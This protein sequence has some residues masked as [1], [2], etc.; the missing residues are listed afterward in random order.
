MLNTTSRAPSRKKLSLKKY[1]EKYVIEYLVVL[2]REV[3]TLRQLREL[4]ANIKGVCIDSIRSIDIKNLIKKLLEGKVRCCMSKSAKSTQSGYVISADANI[5]PDAI[6]AM[7]TGEGV[8]NYMQLKTIS[9]H[10]IFKVRR[11]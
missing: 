11:K 9:C 4:Y 2:K 10:S 6:N 7:V 3:Y 8:T 1:V 5:L